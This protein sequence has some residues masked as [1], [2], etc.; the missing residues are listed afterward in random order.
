MSAMPNRN[1]NRE[2][3]YK[4]VVEMIEK[5]ENKEAEVSATDLANKFGIK[6][7]TMDYHLNKL[8]EEGKLEILSRRG[9]YN[10]K[11]Y[12]LPSESKDNNISEQEQ[13]STQVITPSKSSESYNNY[14]DFLASLDDKI[15]TSSQKDDPED[16]IEHQSPKEEV[17][18]EENNIPEHYNPETQPRLEESIPSTLDTRELTLDEKIERFINTSNQLPDAS[19]LLRHEDREILAVMNET[20]QQN[21]LYLQDL[22][23]QLST[24]QNKELIQHLIDDRKRLEDQIKRLEDEVEIARNQAKQVEE[25]FEI[26][27]QRIRLMHQLAI[28]TLDDYLNQPNHSLALRRKD[29]RNKMTK[30]LNDLVNYALKIEK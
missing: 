5:N 24:I 19:M 28:S 12:K 23:Q 13:K 18:E 26:D 27:P 17:Q 4:E 21:I 2:D 30:E 25:Q 6:S 9:K 22:S 10:R 29:F 3:V 11:I 20:I 8:V 16:L 7:P 1:I 14:K 15:D